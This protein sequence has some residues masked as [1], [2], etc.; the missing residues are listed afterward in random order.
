MKIFIETERLIL[1][2]ILPTDVEGMFELDADEEV[3]RYLGNNPVSSKEQIVEAIR[4]I[5]QQYIDN[6]IGRWAVIDKNTNDFIGWAGLKLV[7]DLTNKH[8]DYYDLGYRLIKRYW[9]KGIGTE[10]AMASLDY[11]FNTLHTD[12][13]YAMVD[14]ENAGSNKILKKVGLNFVEQFELDGTEHNWYKITKTEYENTKLN[15]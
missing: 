8:K 2:E 4:F 1:R 15:L 7:T 11:A 6:G 12:A 3:H 10:A 13:V 9:G 14:C 5:R